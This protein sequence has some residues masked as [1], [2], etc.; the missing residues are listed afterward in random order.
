MIANVDAKVAR[1]GGAFNPEKQDISY[2]RD[3]IMEKGDTAVSD[4]SVHLQCRK[5]K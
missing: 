2:L 4:T 5:F 1:G 3:K